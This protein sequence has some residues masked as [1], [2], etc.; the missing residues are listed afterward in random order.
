MRWAARNRGLPSAL[1]TTRPLGRG[2][3]HEFRE[4][5]D[6]PK[7]EIERSNTSFDAIRSARALLRMPH[8]ARDPLMPHANWLDSTMRTLE[9][10]GG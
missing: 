8:E 7:E 6:S 10:F 4:T 5:T 1:R 3:R 9:H 2:A